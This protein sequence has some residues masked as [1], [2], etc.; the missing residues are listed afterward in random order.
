M[1]HRNIAR[2]LGRGTH[3]DEI[4]FNSLYVALEYVE[5]ENLRK[6]IRRLHK[7]PLTL[8]EVISL[9]IQLA[10][11]ISYMHERGLVAKT[12]EPEHILL[13]SDGEIKLAPFGFFAT[14]ERKIDGTRL[15]HFVMPKCALCCA[16]ERDARYGV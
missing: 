15:S 3:E 6:R 7:E 5:G 11:G 13:S 2:I 8:K 9:L 10:D 1:E 14:P 4:G 16:G 12:L